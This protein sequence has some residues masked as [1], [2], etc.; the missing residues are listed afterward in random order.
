MSSLAAIV[1]AAASVMTAPELAGEWSVAQGRDEFK[2]EE[3]ELRLDL[4]ADGVWRLTGAYSGRAI[5]RPA[6]EEFSLLEEASETDAGRMNEGRVVRFV[7]TTKRSGAMRFVS[8]QLDTGG[9]PTRMEWQLRDR[10]GKPFRT[11]FWM[12][13]CGD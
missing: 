8:R 1:F 12:Q 7:T 6:D 9:R 5:K 2:C 11:L 10:A 3:P 13:R 4:K